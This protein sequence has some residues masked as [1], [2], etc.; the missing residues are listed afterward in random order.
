[1]SQTPQY[2]DP[3]PSEGCFCGG[4]ALSKPSWWLL[5]RFSAVGQLVMLEHSRSVAL[6]PCSVFQASFL[7]DQPE[8]YLPFLSHFIET[9]M[10]ATFIDNKIISQWEE[11]DPFLRV[12]DSRIEKIRL[13][14]VRAPA[15]RTSNYQKCSTLKEAGT[16]RWANKIFRSTMSAT[17]RYRSSVMGVLQPVRKPDQPVQHSAVSVVLRQKLQR[18]FKSS[19]YQEPLLFFKPT[20]LFNKP[21]LK[22]GLQAGAHCIPFQAA[23]VPPP[24]EPSLAVPVGPAPAT[25]RS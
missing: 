11:K 9:Q 24:A 17:R 14:N 16:F 3:I 22:F 15:L 4:E 13:Y 8:P 2:L 10:F 23:P 1:M 18:S 21:K 5:H 6:M 12:F 19:K 25:P 20:G 7:S